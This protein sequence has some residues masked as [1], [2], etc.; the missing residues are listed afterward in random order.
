MISTADAIRRVFVERRPF[1][2]G[3]TVRLIGLD[4]NHLARQIEDRELDCLRVSDETALP[5]PEVAYLALRRWPLDVIFEALGDDASRS[6]PE[7]LR[8]RNITVTLPT[9]QIRALEVL[10]HDQRLDIDTYLQ[11]HL[12]DLASAESPFLAEQIHGY[13]EALHFPFG[14]Q[15]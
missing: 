8:P 12:L 1:T 11:L 7:L 14:G 9:Y 2:F 6:I 13:L 15:R 5:W 10:A 3:E 4:R